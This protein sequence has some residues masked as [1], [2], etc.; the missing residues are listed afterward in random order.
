MGIAQNRKNK[1]WLGAPLVLHEL[2]AWKQERSGL[3][4]QVQDEHKPMSMDMYGS[5]KWNSEQSSGRSCTQEYHST[6][7]SPVRS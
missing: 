2:M 4:N 3:L 5:A 7:T 6:D 1:L